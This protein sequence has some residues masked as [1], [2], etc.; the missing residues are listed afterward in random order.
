MGVSLVVKR[1]FARSATVP[2]HFNPNRESSALS[3]SPSTAFSSSAAEE[4][5]DKSI[6][7]VA[8]VAAP[9][10]LTIDFS[11]GLASQPSHPPVCRQSS[12][13]SLI[14]GSITPLRSK[15]GCVRFRKSSRYACIAF[16]NLTY[17]RRSFSFFSSDTFMLMPAD[18][19][20]KKSTN[21]KSAALLVVVALAGG[22]AKTCLIGTTVLS[23]TLVKSRYFPMTSSASNMV[24]SL[25]G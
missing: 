1:R 15:R 25:M 11:A 4:Y 16:K 20:D 6:P 18:K 5:G 21:P 3:A 14:A 7:L 23:Y 2:P 17:F 19:S 8:S 13:N 12:S 9:S 10:E 22:V 24:P